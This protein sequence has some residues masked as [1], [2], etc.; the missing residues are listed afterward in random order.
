MQAIKALVVDYEVNGEAS[1]YFDKQAEIFLERPNRFR[2]ERITG[3]IVERRDLTHL[4][5]GQTITVIDEGNFAA[6]DKPLRRENFF[7]GV[8]FLVQFFFDPRPISFD[9]SDAAWGRAISLF[10]SNRAAYD[11]NTQLSS[12]GRQ[13]VNGVAYRV[14][15]IKYNTAKADIRQQIYIG[16]DD[17]IYQVDSYFGGSG[18]VS[19]KFHNYRISAALPAQTWQRKLPNKIPAITTDPVLKRRTLPCR[20]MAAVS[21][22]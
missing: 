19:Q 4:S 2:V 17:L 13:V 1:K 14:V 22:R 8:N 21:S 11:K 20:A 3:V 7:L 6:F 5:D 10:D 18:L 12:L 16:Q 15:E 9:P